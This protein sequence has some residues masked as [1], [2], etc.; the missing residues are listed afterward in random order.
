MTEHTGVRFETLFIIFINVLRID[1]VCIF[2]SIFETLFIIFETLFMI[3]E[4]LFIIFVKFRHYFN[5]LDIICL[6]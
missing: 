2:S 5:E 6:N 4:T 1:I 3:F